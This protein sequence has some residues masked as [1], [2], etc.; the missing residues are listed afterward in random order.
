MNT[1]F[2]WGG[3]GWWGGGS[4]RGKLKNANIIIFSLCC[5]ILR[6]PGTGNV[7]V[8]SMQ[9]PELTGTCVSKH[10]GKTPAIPSGTCVC[11]YS[12]K[13]PAIPAGTCV[14]GHSGKTP[15]IPAGT[16]VCGHSGKTPAMFI[17]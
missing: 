5:G 1:F 14:C 3:V 16:C 9:D 4:F 17:K 11:G 2:K 6:R 13:T 8:D 12:D 7:Y 10:S 15:A